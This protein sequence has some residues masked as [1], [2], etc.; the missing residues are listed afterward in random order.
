MHL[1]KTPQAGNHVVTP[2]HLT[3]RI[4]TL[5]LKPRELIID[6]S[7]STVVTSYIKNGMPRPNPGDRCLL[8]TIYRQGV[9]TP[10]TTDIYP[11]LH[12]VVGSITRGFLLGIKEDREGAWEGHQC[13]GDDKQD[14]FYSFST[15]P[16]DVNLGGIIA[17]DARS[18]GPPVRCDLFGRKPSH[19][20]PICQSILSMG[21]GGCIAYRS[22]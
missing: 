5:E 13:F 16:V 15:D 18:C 19:R 2:H 1:V 6:K 8:F 22:V 4:P 21:R 17:H 3:A 14:F 20:D 11:P 9:E 10:V 12:I 7:E